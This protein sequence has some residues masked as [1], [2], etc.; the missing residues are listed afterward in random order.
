VLIDIIVNNIRNIQIKV[1][2]LKIYYICLVRESHAEVF[3]KLVNVDM[4]KVIALTYVI[5]LKKMSMDLVINVILVILGL[6]VMR[7]LFLEL[8]QEEI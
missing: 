3:D 1:L 4:G 6:Y 5:N 7:N 8:K 2:S